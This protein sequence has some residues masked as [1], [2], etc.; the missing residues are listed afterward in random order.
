MTNSGCRCRQET[1]R[2]RSVAAARVLSALSMVVTLSGLLAPNPSSAAEKPP[3]PGDYR[4]NFTSTYDDSQQPYRLFIP[5]KAR[6]GEP[7]PLLVVLHGKWVDENAW[8]D[9]T[10]IKEVAEIRGWVVVAPFSRGNYYYRGAGEQDVLDIIE[11]VKSKTSIRED[12]VFL[13]GHSMGGWGTW[14][15]GL[16]HPDLFVTIAPMAGMAPVELLPNALHLSPFIIHD[17]GDPIVPV[18]ESRIAA[19]HLVDL[20]IPFRYKEET[21]YGHSSKMIGDNLQYLFDWMEHHP[22]VERPR[23]VSFVTRSPK[24]GKAYWLRILKTTKFPQLSSVKAE[25]NTSSTLVIETSNVEQMAIDLDRLPVVLDGPLPIEIDG[26][27]IQA[28][29]QERWLVLDREEN[30]TTYSARLVKSL[31]DWESSLLSTVPRNYEVGDRIGE[32]AGALGTHLLRQAGGDVCLVAYDMFRLP[33]G[34]LTADRLLDVFVPADWRL[35]TFEIDGKTL[36][37]AMQPD[38]V[39]ANLRWGMFYLVGDM[40]QPEATVTVLSTVDVAQQF[41]VEYQ[42][43][44]GILPEYL[45]KAARGTETFP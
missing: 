13:M 39:L 43:L 31:P 40:P 21:G 4:L 33:Q 29:Y 19:H 5:R 7:L 11:E 22:T 24:V 12:R 25:V 37:E 26:I 27:P 9:Y 41:D 20:G 44:P 32:L 3:K 30:P 38:S 36:R 34:P 8:F 6:T 16:R 28:P 35:A 10:P 18:E 14:W 45:I 1:S 15:I 23:R 42:I 2:I 17:T